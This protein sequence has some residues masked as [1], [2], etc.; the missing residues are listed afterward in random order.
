[1]PA[2]AEDWVRAEVRVP[3]LADSSSAAKKKKGKAKAAPQSK[4]P[5]V[6]DPMLDFSQLASR[7]KCQDA[8]LL[9]NIADAGFSQ[10]LPIQQRA[11]PCIMAARDMYAVAP[12]GSGK[13]LAFLLPG[14]PTAGH[15]PALPWSSASLCSSAQQRPAVAQLR[16]VVRARPITHRNKRQRF[17]LLSTLPCGAD[18]CTPTRPAE[19][20]FVQTSCAQ[21]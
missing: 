6:L 3:A 4:V 15:R 10:P 5:D 11:V 7:F 20:D 9:Q 16:G 8:H 17:S 14:A 18:D 12:T 21:R 13:T 19:A 2:E 1:M